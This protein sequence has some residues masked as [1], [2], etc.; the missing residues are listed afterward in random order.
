MA[1]GFS[2]KA[3]L[4][5][6]VS[7]SEQA[8]LGCSLDSQVE[9][10]IAYCRMGG[11]EV[12][13]VVREEGVSGT[14]HLANR[15]GGSRLLDL[16]KTKKVQHVVAL[17]LDRLF[18]NASDA[19]HTTEAWDKQ[20]ISLHFVDMGGM[21]VDT[22]SAMGRMMLTM[23]AG[24]AQF[25]RDLCAERTKSALKHKKTKREVY[26]PV[27]LGFVQVGKQLVADASEQAIISTIQA[28]RAAG[29]S[30]RAIA[31]ELT[32]GGIK[33]KKGGNWYASTIKAILD[34]DLHTLAVTA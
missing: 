22:S 33:T 18:R 13:E 11:L 30:L 8:E 19:L 26:S 9:R 23:L 20:G 16:I 5:I 31:A 32:Q 14:K 15:P 28:L 4:Y 6:R 27:P 24:F 3:A 25:E 1:K 34:N 21:A 10:L 7:T 17:K 29:K 2:K 12:V